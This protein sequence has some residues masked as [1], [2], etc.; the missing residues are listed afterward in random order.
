ML[1]WFVVS[2]VG[3]VGG[4]LVIVFEFFWLIM[5]FNESLWCL[6][7]KIVVMVMGWGVLE[8]MFL[9][10]YSIVVMVFVL[11]FV[12]GVIMG[13]IFG[14]IIVLFYFD[15]SFGMFVVVGVVFGIVVYVVNFYGM[16]VVFFWFVLECGLGLLLVNLLFGVVVVIIYGMLEWCV[17]ELMY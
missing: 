12:L 4:V 3:F 11:Y 6:I 16:M 5:V 10:S 17:G 1:D 9:F 8:E 13:M 15:L 7:Y 2:V 14:V